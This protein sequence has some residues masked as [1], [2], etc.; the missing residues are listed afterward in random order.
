MSAPEGDDLRIDGSI[1]VY[2]LHDIGDEVDLERA[3]SCL[4]PHEPERKRPS[5]AEAQALVIASPPV[6]AS[7]GVAPLTLG[8]FTLDAA[9]TARV[10]DFAVVSLRLEFRMPPGMLWQEFLAFAR[11]ID[12][13][14]TASPVLDLALDRL[15]DR[16]KPAIDRPHLATV[17]EDYI[18]YRIEALRDGDGKSVPAS[19]LHDEDLAPLLLGEKKPLA[20][21]A[22]RELLPNRFSYYPDD[23]AILG[24]Y[25]SLV[26]EPDRDDTDV[27]YVLEFANAQLLELRVYDQV[28]DRELPKVH[29]RIAAS[30]TGAVLLGRRFAPLLG[31]LQSLV[32][33]TTE[34]VERAENAFKVTD[35]VYL[36]RIYSAALE[37]FRGRAWRAGIDRKLGILRDTYTMLS[38]ESR[39]ARSEVLELAIVILIVVEIVLGLLRH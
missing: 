5:R 29:A 14:R 24:W 12:L 22:L 34:T 37:I 36:A 26:V 39:A 18:V 32:A 31:E 15:L 23:L 21:S 25:G 30:R 4:A 27:Q 9:I 19:R 7:L 10:F 38:D 6:G 20:A 17:T 33:E 8:E 16:L 3:T 11:G 28:L 2:R 35:D 13:V 1:V